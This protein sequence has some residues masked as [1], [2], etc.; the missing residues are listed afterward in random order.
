MDRSLALLLSIFA[1][2][3]SA[4]LAWRLSDAP[5]PPTPAAR[6]ASQSVSL[7]S[8]PKVELAPQ[9]MTPQAQLE[10]AFAAIWLET[11]TAGVFFDESRGDLLIEG[12]SQFTP[13]LATALSH[14]ELIKRGRIE[15]QG[16]WTTVPSFRTLDGKDDALARL[17]SGFGFSAWNA[18]GIAFARQQHPDE[19]QTNVRESALL[20]PVV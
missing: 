12:L 1:I 19:S 18:S 7:E 16:R 10:A 4:V 15:S 17:E 3:M 13:A 6:G 11:P 5:A 9:A 20:H 2:S 14:A 8:Q